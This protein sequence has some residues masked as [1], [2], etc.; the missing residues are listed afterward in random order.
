MTGK[1]SS[2]DLPLRDEVFYAAYDIERRHGNVVRLDVPSRAVALED[3][4]E[5]RADAVLVASGGTPNRLPVEGGDLDGVLTLRS[6]GD[7]EEIVAAAKGRDT[8]VVVGASFIGL[9]VAA[10]LTALGIETTVVAPEEVPLERTFGRAI[11]SRV[12]RLH[13]EHGVRF[14]LGRGVARLRGGPHVEA[15]RLDDGEELPA[16][17]VVLGVGVRPATSYVRGVD[18]ESDGG[19]AVDDQLRVAGGRYGVW[20][21]GDV[22]AYPDPY[23]GRRLRIEH[24]R[25]AQQQG[26]AAALSM[27]GR[28]EPFHGVPFFWTQQYRL[29][30]GSVGAAPA[31]DE[32]LLAGDVDADDFVAYYL[33]HGA[34]RAAAGT[35]ETQLGAFAELM[36]V[37]RT[38][39]ADVLRAA[40]DT[41]LRELLA[42][43]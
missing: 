10:S 14:R 28:G 5:L 34:V 43:A 32:V 24:W 22:A 36:R 18:L 25:I 23:T 40:P 4:E 15:V 2:E 6:I 7:G 9:E 35:R 37:G 11:G 19:I 26:K 8:A 39:A 29:A 12:R 27:A 17:F 33:D 31:W 21:A 38:P 20:A 1:L 13:E 42:E 16:H 30:I 41:D 3:G